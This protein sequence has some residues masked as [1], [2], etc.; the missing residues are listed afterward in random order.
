MKKIKYFLLF[1]LIPLFTWSQETI[2]FNSANPF[3]FKDIIKKTDIQ[4]EQEVYGILKMPLNFDS[5]YVYPVVIAVAG[6]NGWSKHHYEYL[7]LYLNPVSIFYH[8]YSQGLPMMKK[9]QHY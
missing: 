9:Y 6:S 8:Q 4:I 1:I 7:D 2:Y 5:T 3:S